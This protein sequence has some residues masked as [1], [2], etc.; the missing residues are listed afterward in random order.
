MSGR[1]GLKT[2]QEG[3][4]G[5][6]VWEE[7]GVVVEADPAEGFE[8]LGVDLGPLGLG[9]VDDL[10]MFVSLEVEVE[11]VEVGEMRRGRDGRE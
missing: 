9:M 8:V 3:G 10:E 6:D 2:G 1:G 7:G 11:E 5:A 4:G